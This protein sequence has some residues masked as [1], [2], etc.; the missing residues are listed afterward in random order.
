MGDLNS[1]GTLDLLV[2]AITESTGGAQAGALY[3]LANP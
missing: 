3:F 2:G 1:D